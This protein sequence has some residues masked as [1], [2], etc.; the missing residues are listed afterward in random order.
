MGQTELRQCELRVICWASGQMNPQAMR[1]S[2]LH[3]EYN[4]GGHGR[5]E[6]P[7]ALK[8]GGLKGRRDQPTAPRQ[9]SAIPGMAAAAA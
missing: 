4:S 1:N 6:S 9:A 8:V 7:M 2:K 3:K 5:R